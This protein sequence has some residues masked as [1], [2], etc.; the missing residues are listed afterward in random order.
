MPLAWAEYEL[1]EER[2]ELRRAGAKVPVQP[3]VLELLFVLV[4]AR[5]RVVL[6]RELF[7]TIWAG[8]T[9]S[10]ASLSRAVLEARRAI[11]DELQQV[12]VTV[13]GRGFRFVAEVTERPHEVDRAASAEPASD[14]T[15]VGRESCMTC[16]AAR[17]D[18]ATKGQGSVVWISGEAGIGKTRTADELARRARARGADVYSASGHETAGAPQFWLWAQ[19]LRAHVAAAQDDP[20]LVELLKAVA[21]IMHG[22]ADLSSEAQFALFDTFAR[23]FVKAAEARPQV[24]VFDDA[25]WA[26][27]GSRSLLQFFARE[28]RR[29]AVVIV[30]TYR[31]TE[32]LTD[33][34]ARAF[35]ALLGDVAGLSISLRGLGPDEIPR[36]VLV[37]SGSEPSESFARALYDRTGGN[38]L[39][40]RQVLQTE[41]AERA[42]TESAHELA[43]SMDLQQGLV[44]SIQR[45][46]QSI[47]T[48]GRELLNFA[49]VLGREFELTELAV[50]S[51]QEPEAL[52][53]RLDEGARARILLKSKTGG[54]SFTHAL[55]HDVLY[56]S[57]SSRERAAK[58]AVIA[59]RLSAHYG[60][61]MDAHVAALAYHS[62]RA[63]P[64]GNPER[65]F[66]L[67]ARAAGAA[68]A[69]AD[70][71]GAARH[72]IAA[73]Q[74][75]MHLAPDD[76]R[77]VVAKLGAARE[78]AR[79]GEDDSARAAYLDGATLARTFG[80][81]AAMAEAAL[82]F[83]ALT[84][85]AVATRGV[86]L[87]D[88]SASLRRAGGAVEAEWLPRVTALL[89]ET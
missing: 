59:E 43:S 37:T 56:K 66:E 49:A 8:L 51:A 2:F 28:T 44:E 83:A 36:F 53:D 22:A 40:L 31:D 89:V 41:W 65:A 20:K 72:W 73:T 12:L 87:R 16:L 38:P 74:A 63:L 60:A 17:L 76:A 52:L 86:L 46:L 25:H 15:F 81:A 80:D 13:R 88:A 4:R 64:R 84:G 85:P 82:G 55:V 7:E 18:E 58:H 24:F 69:H 21:P 75:L 79:A 77:H 39:Y 3:K 33:P 30:C 27:D 35:G 47:S 61:S 11:G 32:H 68:S 50:V 78:H 14:P 19:A 26:D 70:P 6:R 54:Y 34:R 29:S 42:L 23:F 10:E 1:D 71:R 57:L 45:H 62:N 67:S 9:V 48:A 5:E